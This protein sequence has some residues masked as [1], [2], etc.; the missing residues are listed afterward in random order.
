MSGLDQLM[1]SLFLV[2]L[3]QNQN[4]LLSENVKNNKQLTMFADNPKWL[5]NIALKR[6]EI[7]LEHGDKN[8][9]TVHSLVFIFITDFTSRHN[10]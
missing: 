1:S 5:F 8:S 3:R 4:I 2:I 10:T 6:L 7:W 9:V